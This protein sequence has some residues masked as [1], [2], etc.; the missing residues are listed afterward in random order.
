MFHCTCSQSEPVAR[1]FLKLD[2]LGIVLS[3][4]GTCISSSYIGL[5]EHT[6][7][8]NLY[9]SFICIVGAAVF[10]VTLNPRFD[11]PRAAKMRYVWTI[12]SIPYYIQLVG[13]CLVDFVVGTNI[14]SAVL[15]RVPLFAT[16][17]GSGFI[18]IAHVAFLD[19]R[20]TA[21]DR[22]P[23]RSLGLMV[24]YYSLGSSFYILRFPEKYWVGK[25]D[26]WVSENPAEQRFS[27][28]HFE[29]LPK[30]SINTMSNYLSCRPR[31]AFDA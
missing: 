27:K 16:F 19:G 15:N 31:T 12:V 2:Y 13:K 22:F 6:L 30:H 20:Q 28:K 7:L 17:V 21:F 10:Q 8:R 18:P 11:G 23:L 3:I 14:G 24:A 1:K 9:I 29:D 26:L 25:F 5:S 4:F